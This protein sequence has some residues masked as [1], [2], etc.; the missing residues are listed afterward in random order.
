MSEIDPDRFDEDRKNLDLI[1]KFF[2]G[3]K[4]NTAVGTTM[5]ETSNEFIFY[6]GKAQ[7]SLIQAFAIA[8]EREEFLRKVN[9]RQQ[10]KTTKVIKSINKTK[11]RKP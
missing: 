8:A 5:H 3:M 7:Q 2:L 1:A 4:M 10:Q 9:E 6:I 11:L